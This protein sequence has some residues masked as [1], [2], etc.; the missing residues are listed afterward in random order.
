MRLVWLRLK[1][2]SWI[3]CLCGKPRHDAVL[4]HLHSWRFW[5]ILSS[6]ATRRPETQISFEAR[7]SDST[8][9]FL[10]SSSSIHFIWRLCVLLNVCACV[11]ECVYWRKLQ[12]NK[13]PL[14][15][16]TRKA[17]NHSK[18]T[19][20]NV[21]ICVVWGWKFSPSVD[22]CRCFAQRC[23]SRFDF[24]HQCCMR[25]CCRFISSLW[26]G[27]MTSPAMS[28]TFFLVRLKISRP[29]TC[30]FIALSVY[31]SIFVDEATSRDWPSAAL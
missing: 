16:V 14:A 9:R 20:K 13:F 4:L 18:P 30:H 5:A 12:A 19:K 23:K 28:N 21:N 15:Q 1:G 27:Y 7:L 26:L 8:I 25:Q 11:S 22:S 6:G 2:Q 10:I 17:R 24:W 29:K 3:R 31:E